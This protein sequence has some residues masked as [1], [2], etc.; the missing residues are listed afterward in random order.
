M[1]ANTIATTS[2][3]LALVVAVTLLSLETHKHSYS[4][5]ARE[6]GVPIF[7]HTKSAD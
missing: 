3:L 7:I 2:A 6:A 4:V 1:V 5:I